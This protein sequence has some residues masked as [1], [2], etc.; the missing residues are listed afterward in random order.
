MKLKIKLV[1]WITLFFVT[2]LLIGFTTSSNFPV[3]WYINTTK[4]ELWAISQKL[5]NYPPREDQLKWDGALTLKS[6][7]LLTQGLIPGENSAPAKTQARPRQPQTSLNF[8]LGWYD[9]IS[10]LNTLEQITQEGMNIVM[11]YTGKSSMEEIETYLDRAAATGIKVL[12]EIPRLEVRRDHR[13][14]ITQF[15][16]KFKTHPAVYGWYLFDEPEFISL[17]PR[18]LKRV[19]RAIKTEDPRHQVAIAFGKPQ[20]IRKYLSALDTV[21]YFNYPVFDSSS[22][23]G[24][25]EIRT[26]KTRLQNVAAITPNDKELWFIL[27]GYGRDKQGRLTKFKRR[28][29]TVAESRYMTYSALLARADGLLFWTHYR[30]QQQWIDRVLS[31]IIQEIQPYLTTGNNQ[32]INCNLLVNNPYLQARLYRNSTTKDLLLIAI[33][34]NNRQISTA[35]ALDEDISVNSARNLTSDRLL[36]LTRGLVQDTFEPYGVHIYQLK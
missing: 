21:M 30:S 7:S 12:L 25:P 23:F 17:S 11:P 14:L 27:Q 16:R 20:Y 1:D 28:L 13:W 24:S 2:V 32:D 9:S 3:N 8:P 4:S 18:L 15:V 33:N 5:S 35:I 29:P 31:P 22:E 36:K 26:F 19:Y 10:N 6:D 34:H